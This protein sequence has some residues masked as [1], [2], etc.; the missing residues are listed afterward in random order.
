MPGRKKG[1][2]NRNKKSKLLSANLKN[3][4]LDLRVSEG[5]LELLELSKQENPA[6]SNSDVL[7]AA[8]H[9]YALG[10]FYRVDF[11]KVKELEDRI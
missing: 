1:S 9:Y 3:K 4:R 8:L 11:K 6:W 7:A 5:F 2:P 10:T